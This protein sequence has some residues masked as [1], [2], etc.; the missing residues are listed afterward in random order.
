[1]A[2]VIAICNRISLNGVR[3][4]RQL[5]DG[6]I[7][8]CLSTVNRRKWHKPNGGIVFEKMSH[9]YFKQLK[10]F[11]IEETLMKIVYTSKY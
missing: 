9:K 2:L 1:M 4:I 6:L 11:L 3:D 8:Y 10:K 7:H 5:S